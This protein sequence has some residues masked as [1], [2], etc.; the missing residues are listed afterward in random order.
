MEDQILGNKGTMELAKGVYYYE[1]DN[2]GSGIQK[3]L[4]QIEEKV[5]SSICG[6]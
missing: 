6:T 4:N 5:F 1:D 2:S 3:L